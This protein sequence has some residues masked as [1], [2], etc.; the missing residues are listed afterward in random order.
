MTDEQLNRRFDALAERIDALA[1]R[2]ERMEATLL[3]EFHT[4]SSPAEARSRGVAT[5]L[6]ALDLE[7][8][9]LADW[10]KKFEE[11]ALNLKGRPPTS[12]E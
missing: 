7:R 2:I 11:R 9:L 12:I 5:A 10:V 4:R 3:T 8:E 1:E 6:R